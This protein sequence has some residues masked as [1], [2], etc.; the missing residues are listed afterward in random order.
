MIIKKRLCEDKFGKDFA[1][2]IQTKM[3]LSYLGNSGK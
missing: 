3:F 2:D 1:M